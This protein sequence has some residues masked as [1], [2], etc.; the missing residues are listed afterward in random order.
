MANKGHGWLY[1]ADENGD[2][3]ELINHARTAAYLQTS[4]ALG[5]ATVSSVLDDGGCEADT[6]TGIRVVRVAVKMSGAAEGA[7]YGAVCITGPLPGQ[8]LGMPR[9][10]HP[11][12]T[13]CRFGEVQRAPERHT[14]AG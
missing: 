8:G 10:W 4:T 12:V 7:S 1:I 6:M 11:K 3:G 5:C 14:E 9:D 2:V 13:S